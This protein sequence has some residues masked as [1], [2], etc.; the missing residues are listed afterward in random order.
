V[1]SVCHQIAEFVSLSNIRAL[2][3]V[4]YIGDDP[5]D[6]FI[7]VNSF[8]RHIRGEN[9]KLVPS[10]ILFSGS[11]LG[12]ILSK[13]GIHFPLNLKRFKSMTSDYIVD[14]QPTWDV[15]DKPSLD[16][17]KSISKTAQWFLGIEK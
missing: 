14:M 11:I 1:E 10:F 7:W 15:I 13:I 8:S 3:K 9:V 17:E 12:E 16:F 4:Y 2:K 6:S 5:I